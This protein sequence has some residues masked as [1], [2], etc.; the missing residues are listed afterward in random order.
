MDTIWYKWSDIIYFSH[1]YIKKPVKLHR[2]LSC[3]FLLT[4]QSSSNNLLHLIWSTSTRHFISTLWEKLSQKKFQ[5]SL[6]LF[7]LSFCWFWLCLSNHSFW[8][9]LVDTVQDFLI[10][11][12]IKPGLHIWE[13]NILSLNNVIIRSTKIMNRADKN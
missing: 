6:E 10:K 1:F 9:S 3:Q 13:I 11:L 7:F 12:G 8:P 4:T 5:A 2:V